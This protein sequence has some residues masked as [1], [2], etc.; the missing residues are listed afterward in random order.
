MTEQQFLEHWK[1]I[2]GTAHLLIRKYRIFGYE[3]EDMLQVARMVLFDALKEWDIDKGSKLNSYYYRKL[4][5]KFQHMLA[6]AHAKR[7]FY[8]YMQNAAFD[9]D[10][11][12]QIVE[13][14]GMTPEEKTLSEEKQKSIVTFIHKH[15]TEEEKIILNLKYHGH[16]NKE[17]GQIMQYTASNVYLKIKNIRKKFKKLN[18]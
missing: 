18:F 7:N 12:L 11:L 15:L 6:R 17:I 2:E 5:W 14:N 9:G 4:E 10:L 16:K 1:S 3:Y 8:N 13:V